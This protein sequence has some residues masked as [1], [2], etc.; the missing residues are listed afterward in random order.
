MSANPLIF[1][2]TGK[3]DQDVARSTFCKPRRRRRRGDQSG[4][5]GYLHRDGLPPEWQVEP[6]KK[7][8]GDR[9][10]LRRT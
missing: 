3:I 6:F 2:I 9:E 5:K 10:A 4:R 1:S 7:H 8:H